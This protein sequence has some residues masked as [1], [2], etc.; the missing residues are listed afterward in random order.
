[1]RIGV[2]IAVGDQTLSGRT[3]A[4]GEFR[5]TNSWHQKS[6]ERASERENKKSNKFQKKE[7]TAVIK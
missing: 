2:C 7:R 1:M 4:A 6:D 3:L 5:D